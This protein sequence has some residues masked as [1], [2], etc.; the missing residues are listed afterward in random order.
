MS[1]G[2]PVE[3]RGVVDAHARALLLRPQLPVRVQL[4]GLPRRRPRR[5]VRRVPDRCPQPGRRLDPQPRG[6]M[7]SS[8]GVSCERV[9]R[10]GRGRRSGQGAR[11]LRAPRV[12]RG[13][14]RARRR[15]TMTRWTPTT[16]PGSRRGVPARAPQRLRPGAAARLPAPT[17]TAGDTLGGGAIGVLAGPGADHQRRDGRRRR[18]G[19]PVPAAARRHRGRRR[20]A[21]LS[22]R[23]T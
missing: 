4:D 21:R 9:M 7:T 6:R 13:L 23:S 22:A 17:S 12:G 11:G 20:R 8:R 15:S 16:S 10:D 14:R 19:R 2:W 18:L 1:D 5:G 3:Y